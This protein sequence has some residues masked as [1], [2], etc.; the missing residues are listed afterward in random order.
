MGQLA[1]KTSISPRQRWA[2]RRNWEKRQMV[3]MYKELI[4]RKDARWIERDIRS[5]TQTNSEIKSLTKVIKLMEKILQ[6]WDHNTG[7]R[8]REI[9]FNKYK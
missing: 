3:Y 6:N 8:R 4:F 2:R 9:N 5:Q 7:I 1:Q